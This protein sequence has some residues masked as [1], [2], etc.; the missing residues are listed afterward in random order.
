MNCDQTAAPDPE[1]AS[2]ASA[3]PE[4]G[5]DTPWSGPAMHGSERLMLAILILSLVSDR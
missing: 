3:G 2:G 4:S 1:T 5:A